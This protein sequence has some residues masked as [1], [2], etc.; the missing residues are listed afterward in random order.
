MENKFVPYD[1]VDK[2]NW[3][4]IDLDWDPETLDKFA[5]VAKLENRTVNDWVSK[6]MYEWWQNQVA[7]GTWDESLKSGQ[8]EVPLGDKS[9]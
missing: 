5:E 6:T 9:S 3:V 4:S 8:I 2:T 7:N 1:E